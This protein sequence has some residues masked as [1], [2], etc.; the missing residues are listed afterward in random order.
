MYR[1]ITVKGCVLSIRLFRSNFHGISSDSVPKYLFKLLN[2][3]PSRLG[4]LA[5]ISSLIG[6][7]DELVRQAVF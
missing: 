6:M 3:L 4:E 2:Y 5:E 7:D 1:G